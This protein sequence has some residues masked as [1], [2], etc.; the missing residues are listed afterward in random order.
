MKKN[1][2]QEID[3]GLALYILCHL[4]LSVYDSKHH[5]FFFLFVHQTTTTTHLIPFHI[6]LVNTFYFYCLSLPIY[7]LDLMNPRRTIKWI[8][9]IVVYI[10]CIFFTWKGCSVQFWDQYFHHVEFFLTS[11]SWLP[12][13]FFSKRSLAI[14]SCFLPPTTNSV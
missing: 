6:W 2:V 5:N 8:I 3:L 4:F 9:H 11:I 1:K 14:L 12:F 13:H 10:F 7:L